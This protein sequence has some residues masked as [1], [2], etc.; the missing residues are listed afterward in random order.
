MRSDSPELSRLP[1][2]AEC[3]RADLATVERLVHDVQVMAG[4]VIVSERESP[5][6]SFIIIEGEA[7]LAACDHS[8]ARLGPGEF[9]GWVARLR[10][11]QPQAATVTAITPMRCLVVPPGNLGA[12]LDIPGI[13]RS[14]LGTLVVGAARPD[15]VR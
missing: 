7:T 15:K 14:V 8:I 2:F 4:E 1:L 5:D 12:L 3:S 10:L 9:F 13:A 11:E 6:D